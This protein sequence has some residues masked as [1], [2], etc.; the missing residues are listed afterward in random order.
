MQE[1]FYENLKNEIDNLNGVYDVAL[2]HDKIAKFLLG[3]YIT[4]DM[5]LELKEYAINQQGDIKTGT[6]EEQ[7]VDLTV[8][9]L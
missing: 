7:V 4:I 2:I 5:A 8:R 6:L 9:S 1:N 3:D